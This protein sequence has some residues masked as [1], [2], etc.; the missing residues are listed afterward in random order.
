MVWMISEVKEAANKLAWRAVDQYY[1][2][3]VGGQR[4][5]GKRTNIRAPYISSFE[6][7]ILASSWLFKLASLS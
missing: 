6:D 4:E 5:M 7:C 2:V 1:V 3:H